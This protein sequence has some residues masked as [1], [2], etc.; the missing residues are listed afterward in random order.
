MSITGYI[1]TLNAVMAHEYVAIDITGAKEK[2]VLEGLMNG[3]EKHNP[4]IHM[5]MISLKFIPSP[6][7]F[8]TILVL[9]EGLGSLFMVGLKME[10][11]WI[12]IFVP[13]ITSIVGYMRQAFTDDVGRTI[14]CSFMKMSL[15]YFD[16]LTLRDKRREPMMYFKSL[17]TR[18]AHSITG[19]FDWGASIVINLVLSII[20]TIVIF[21]L[22]G[23]VLFVVGGIIVYTIFYYLRIIPLQKKMVEEKKKMREQSMKIESSTKWTF[24]LFQWRK[25]TVEEVLHFITEEYIMYMK[26]GQNWVRVSFE[27]KIAMVIII[28]SFL[29]TSSSFGELMML[30]L[31]LDQVSGIIESI[32]GFSNQLQHYVK[33][34]EAFYEWYDKTKGS[35]DEVEQ[36]EILEKGLE[37]EKVEISFESS[38][39]KL[40]AN[41]LMIKPC[42]AILLSGKSG[43]GKTQLINSLMGY[44][45]G[46]TLKNG[47]NPRSY[48][49]A[50]EYLNQQT[51]ESLPSHGFSLR[52]IIDNEKDNSFIEE[53]VRIVKLDSK[54][55]THESFDEEMKDFSGGESMRIALFF[56]LWELMKKNKNILVLDEPEQGLDEETRCEVIENI[57]QYCRKNS[58]AVLCV[59]HGSRLDYI[60]MGFTK[61]WKFSQHEILGVRNT[62]VE[63]DDYINFKRSVARE[64]YGEIFPFV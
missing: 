41:D 57:I 42:D 59:Y 55:K 52:D 37:F 43:C 49:N 32:S 64:I 24:N 7:I 33:D 47:E 39:F 22:N 6:F 5:M 45:D 27:M 40:Q 26:F 31:M 56:T 21:V 35:I 48:M 51:R 16:S 9:S 36:L 23:N 58:K 46:A 38:S 14:Y 53:L 3:K 13:V 34:I 10:S 54:F 4:F 18:T 63:C 30:K 61:V 15:D 44:I 29:L 50:I 60:R 8:F 62:H 1:A 19:I 2:T 28:T 11:S 12:V 25:R 17:L 20:T